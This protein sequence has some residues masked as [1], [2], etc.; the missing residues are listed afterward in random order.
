MVPGYLSK[1]QRDMRFALEVARTTP[2]GDIPVGAVLFS[3][4]GE[5]IGTGTN[6]PASCTG[7]SA[8]P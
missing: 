4:T 8:A 1:A 7:S 2:P 5:I 3:P 6:R